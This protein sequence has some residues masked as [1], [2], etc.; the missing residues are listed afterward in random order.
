MN[1]FNCKYWERDIGFD[2]NEGKC[3][4][5]RVAR[6]R[7]KDKEMCTVYEEGRWVSIDLIDC[8]PE[9]NPQRIID[10]VEV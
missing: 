9:H 10:E 6:S 5:G 3:H 2:A 7:T 8:I 1:C 4:N